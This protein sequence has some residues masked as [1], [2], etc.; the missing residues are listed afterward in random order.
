M[1]S[2]N[3]R[4]TK[5]VRNRLPGPVDYRKLAARIKRVSDPKRLV[6]LLHMDGGERCVGDLNAGLG[7]TMSAASRHLAILRLA[8]LV[9]CR[10][11]A[12]RNLYK[13]TEAGRS[14]LRV[15]KELID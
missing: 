2:S 3:G 9:I 10:R 4:K 1:S 14:L 6:M 15:A 8:G 7:T 11:D 5:A 12:Q 13:L